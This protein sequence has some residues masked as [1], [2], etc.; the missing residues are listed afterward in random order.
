MKR[1]IF[2]IIP[3]LICWMVFTG[4]SS[5]LATDDN[6]KVEATDNG[7]DE[8]GTSSTDENGVNL[9]PEDSEMDEDVTSLIANFKDVPPAHIPYEVTFVN[10]SK[11]AFAY[12]WDFGDGNLSSQ[13]EPK[14]TYINVTLTVAGEDLSFASIT[15]PVIVFNNKDGEII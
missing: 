11:N 9:E 6:V 10:T 4:C 1:L 3:A 8:K 2:M 7:I 13:K 5:E 14:H 12:K 15:K